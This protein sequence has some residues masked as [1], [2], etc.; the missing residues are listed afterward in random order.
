MPPFDRPARDSSLLLGGWSV[1]V[2]EAGRARHPGSWVGPEHAVDEWIWS[3]IN[4][5]LARN[6]G[7]TILIDAGTG[8]LGPWWPYEGFACDL[9]AAVARAGTSLDEIDRVILTHLDF[10]HVGGLLEGAWPETLVPVLPGVEVVVMSDAVSAAR[11]ADPDAPLNAA[12][13]AVAVLEEARL[14]VQAEDGAEVAPGLRLR[15]APGHQ[16]GHAM[17]EIGADDPLVF[18]ADVF[19]HTL[20]AAHPEWDSLGDED[21]ALALATRRKVLSALADTG[22]PV[23]AAHVSAE[24]PLSVVTDACAWR[25]EPWAGRVL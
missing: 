15:S 4:V 1:H 9:G 12:T 16:P 20:H 22:R 3:P 8:I 25:L 6:S 24:Q 21:P 5:V 11:A 13:R 23:F 17:V 19:H 7:E 18:V 2:L 10:D 14:I